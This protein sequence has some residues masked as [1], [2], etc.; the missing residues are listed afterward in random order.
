MA[1][2]LKQRPNK[3]NPNPIQEGMDDRFNISQTEVD[4]RFQDIAKAE[5]D[6]VKNKN[7]ITT[8]DGASTGVKNKENEANFVNNFKKSSKKATQTVKKVGGWRKKTLY[9]GLIGGF[10]GILIT[11]FMAFLPYKLLALVETAQTAASRVPGYALEK[12]SEYI[13]KRMIMTRITQ[14]ALGS[15][16]KDV[17]A[18][19]CKGGGLACS[20][21]KTYTT[22]FIEER[23]DLRM[24]KVGNGVEIS[25]GTQRN[26]IGGRGQKWTVEGRRIT[27]GSLSG[28]VDSTKRIIETLNAGQMMDR[29]D[30]EIKI[31]TKGSNIITR[32]VV[33]R[34]LMSKYGIP[35]WR[36][37]PL[38]EK[39]KGGL[40]GVS[41]F[42]TRLGNGQTR[43]GA[44]I[45]ANL[46]GSLNKRFSVYMGCLDTSAYKC[47][48]TLDEV[49]KKIPTPEELD[50]KR[51]RELAK[52]GEDEDKKNKI[53]EKYEKRKANAEKVRTSLGNFADD[54]ADTKTGKAI[55]KVISSKIFKMLAATAGVAAFIGG[56][57]MAF[58]LVRFVDENII[59]VIASDVRA[60]SAAQLAFGGD[61]GIVT[62]AERLKTGN[63]EIG[64]VASIA[65]LF[66]NA[67]AAPILSVD[68]GLKSSSGT[69][70]TTCSDGEGGYET[71]QLEP[72]QSVCPDLQLMKDYRSWIVNL[73]GSTV[74]GSLTTISSGWN[75][76]VGK[77]IDDASEVASKTSEKILGW[78]V[79]LVPGLSDLIG[80]V[81]GFLMRQL[82]K[83]ISFIF[84]PPVFGYEVPGSVN[85]MGLSM[86]MRIAQNMSM[87][88]GVDE[89]GKAQGG[90]GAFLTDQQ[91]AAITHEQID[92][93]RQHFRNQS[94]F[95]RLFNPELQNSLVN[96]IAIATPT[97]LSGAVETAPRIAFGGITN[98]LRSSVNATTTLSQNPYKQILYGYSKETNFQ[99]DPVEFNEETC[100]ESRKAREESYKFVDD[101]EAYKVYTKT[102]PCAL[103]KIIVGGL[104]TDAGN[105][106]DP[107]ALKEPSGNGSLDGITGGS[108]TGKGKFN[109]TGKEVQGWSTVAANAQWAN[110]NLK[111]RMLGVGWCAY[112]SARIWQGRNT[113]YGYK[114]AILMPRLN[115]RILNAGDRSPPKGALLFSK[116]KSQYGHVYIY[117]GNNKILNDGVVTDASYVEERWKQRYIGWIDPNDLG[118]KARPISG[119]IGSVAPKATKYSPKGKINPIEDWSP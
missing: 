64:D 75:S 107:L 68:Q 114:W 117:L 72:G 83:L 28:K 31:K 113:S 91:V 61:S 1:V 98:S 92:K 112:I 115:K 111:D 40:D 20:L 44:K 29:L 82:M 5:N 33:R 26:E 30:K 70:S 99:T 12:R 24:K 58:K 34:V 11:G 7:N 38:P 94:V 8:E 95:A 104:S 62:N 49:N 74:W 109:D 15:S 19:F 89:Y 47:Q 90:G 57:D 46:V 37:L 93:E 56:L 102:D 2:Q 16:D 43:V 101:N 78:A 50:K 69:L 14:V 86:G 85:Y 71:V 103:E 54:N 88:G 32:Y 53:R 22:N 119:S 76:S 79:R 36:G 35:H 18:V 100:E 55:Q 97:S 108:S 27:G 105:F 4:R 96:K 60:N 52:A 59:G 77:L 73:V 81:Q 106:D 9:G 42:F 3:D 41:N 66:D 116:G 65:S 23:Y 48:Q 21:F 17:N 45:N 87:S 51:D 25:I 39:V 118:W 13:V 10:G 80:N 110:K 6:A 84:D 67:S 63:L